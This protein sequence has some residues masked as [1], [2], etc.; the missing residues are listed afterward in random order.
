ML[1]PHTTK[2][3]IEAAIKKSGSINSFQKRPAR[4]YNSANRRRGS[5]RTVSFTLIFDD[6]PTLNTPAAVQYLHDR[7]FG[8]PTWSG[9]PDKVLAEALVDV[10]NAKGTFLIASPKRSPSALTPSASG[11]STSLSRPP[12]KVVLS[13][14]TRLLLGVTVPERESEAAVL[15]FIAKVRAG[16]EPGSNA[17][18][19]LKASTGL[20]R[21]KLDLLTQR[22]IHPPAETLQL[23]VDDIVAR[24]PEHRKEVANQLAVDVRA[25]QEE[26][27][28]IVRANMQL[29]RALTEVVMVMAVDDVER[30]RIGAAIRQFEA[31]RCFA[32]QEINAV[33]PLADR[34]LA[35]NG[36]AG[37]S[38]IAR[39]LMGAESAFL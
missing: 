10:T 6:E 27:Q 37:S 4:K 17:T 12:S 36:A 29:A 13:A 16:A 20:S 25:V 34:A 7:A 1:E 30:Q 33:L 3:A 24:K 18:R 32:V 2:A 8:G 26:T 5:Q 9:V 38:F 21:Q 19:N 23:R 35:E 14:C 15:E 28:Q 22:F 31:T 39:A 11:S